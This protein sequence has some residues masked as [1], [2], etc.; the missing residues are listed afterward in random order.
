MWIN[1]FIAGGIT[2]VLLELLAMFLYIV[3]NGK[4]K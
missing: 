3:L 1:P 2:A 4:R